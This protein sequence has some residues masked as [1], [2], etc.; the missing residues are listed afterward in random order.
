MKTQ[1]E[2]KAID[3]DELVRRNHKR[4]VSI[5]FSGA[6]RVDPSKI[7]VREY[8]ANRSLEALERMVKQ[9]LAKTGS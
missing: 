4:G 9:R 6:I 8:E 3:L 2:S 5:S 1:T 7:L